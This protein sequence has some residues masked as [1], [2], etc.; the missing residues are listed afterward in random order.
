[1]CFE[2]SNRKLM[3]TIFE[4]PNIVNWWDE[5]IEKYS[6]I[7][8]EGKPSY[9]AYAENGGMNFYREN[10]SIKELVKLAEQPFSKATDEYFYEND[11]FDLEG[12]CGG[13]CVVF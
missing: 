12:D 4:E 7:P 13:G 6:K 11:L 1:M 3:T 10:R 2:K 9:N 8:L 5:M